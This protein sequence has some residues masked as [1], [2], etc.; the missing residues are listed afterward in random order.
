MNPK[1]VNVV[2]L[3]VG[4]SENKT[5]SKWVH[6][7]GFDQIHSE[8]QEPAQDLNFFDHKDFKNKN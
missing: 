2:F 7:F 5:V 3:R 1:H 4:K 8:S 6:D